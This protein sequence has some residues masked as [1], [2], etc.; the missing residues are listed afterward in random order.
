MG[1]SQMLQGKRAVIFGAGGS[2]GAA[3]ASE[4]AAEGAEVFLA[5]RTRSNVEAVA[6]RIG[7]AGHRAHAV[8][9]DALDDAAVNTYVDGV[10]GD[11]GQIDIVFTAVGPLANEYGNTKHATDLT[12]DEF[13]LPLTTVVKSQFIAA[14][15]AARH[16]IKQRS[17]VIVFLTGS[18]ARGHVEGATAIGTAFGAIESLTENL[19]VEVSPFGVR[20]VCLRTTA[21]TD[22]RT[23][24]QTMDAV[25]SKMQI[26][27]EQALAGMANLNFLK[28]PATVS[29]TAKAA[30]LLASD[31]ARLL[32][33]TVVN[34][35]GGAALD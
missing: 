15:A 35:T 1:D 14:R 6:Q 2:I 24:Q 3:V 13:M 5:G 23:M 10:V 7:K 22:S 19:A 20:V 12:I 8:V 29:D 34:S 18:P 26:T 32:T 21:N 16:M 28:V 27:K 9:I 30:V 25:V 11:A 33:G 17:G 31:R 4:F